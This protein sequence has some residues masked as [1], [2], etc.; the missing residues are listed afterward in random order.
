MPRKKKATLRRVIRGLKSASLRS[1]VEQK[2][3]RWI[4]GRLKW[5][6]SL[7]EA[8][9]KWSPSNELDDCLWNGVHEEEFSCQH[10]AMHS[11]CH[12]KKDNQEVS[13]R[14]A[15]LAIKHPRANIRKVALQALLGGWPD[16]PGLGTAIEQADK[17]LDPD[18]K[19]LAISSRIAKQAA[20]RSGQ[21]SS[22]YIRT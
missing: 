13:D 7:Y 5:R 16:H 19:V 15:E 4:P 1:V 8:I 14:F 20:N 22:A 11:L 2:L 17:S 6:A 21:G 10:A 9:S 12:V 18:L 3:T